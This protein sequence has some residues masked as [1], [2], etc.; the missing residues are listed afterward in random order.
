MDLSKLLFTLLPTLLFC[1]NLL[2]LQKY[3]SVHLLFKLKTYCLLLIYYLHITKFVPI[4]LHLYLRSC[5]LLQFSYS[6]FCY[7]ILP[8]LFLSSL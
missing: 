8:A 2:L 4:Y 6:P 7:V 3:K 1:T 5:I